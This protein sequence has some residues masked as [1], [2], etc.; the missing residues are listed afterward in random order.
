MTKVCIG[1]L[2]HNEAG[3]IRPLFRDLAKQEIFSDASL[4]LEI[5]VVANGCDDSTVPVSHHELRQ[6]AFVRENVRIFVHDLKVAG[7][8]NA[9]NEFV[10]ILAPSD[11][12]YVFLLDADIRIPESTT[13]SL[14]L[15]T[16]MA[17]QAAVVA[18]DESVKDLSLET[19]RTVAEWLIKAGTGTANDTRVAIAGALYC[20]RFPELQR[21]WMPTGLPGED[22]FLLA[23]VLT[24]QFSKPEDFGRLVFV[25]GARHIFESERTWSGVFRHNVRLAI[26]TQIN[27]LLFHHLREQLKNGVAIAEYIKARNAR[28]STWVNDLV[29]K[30]MATGARLVIEPA[31]FLR[32]YR[33]LRQLPLERQ[34]RGLPM[35]II[36]TLFD[37]LV[38]ARANSLLRAGKGAG[39][40]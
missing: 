32:R 7:K 17:K 21:I 8:S 38:F 3:R 24:S 5:H 13:L 33:R 39:F 27:I 31:L 14:V 28:S 15:S 22:G 18:V 30:K 1:I 2:A 10:H 12:D 25:E 11:T 20:A 29:E 34:A 35:L 9:W 4:R 36:G 23:M 6:P 37:A 19:P 40:W 26:G 16:L